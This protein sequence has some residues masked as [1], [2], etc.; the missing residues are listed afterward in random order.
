MGLMCERSSRARSIPT[1]Q[2]EGEQA[3]D[4]LDVVQTLCQ[5][6]V[7]MQFTASIWDFIV[8][9]WNTAMELLGGLQGTFHP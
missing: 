3:M 4:L 8:E 5:S 1:G 9:G 7:S 2:F 6:D